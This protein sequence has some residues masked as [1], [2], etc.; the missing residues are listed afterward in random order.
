MT[1]PV[2]NDSAPAPPKEA[3]KLCFESNKQTAVLSSGAIVLIGTFLSTIFPETDGTLVLGLGSKLLLAGA[4]VFLG[5][6]L[7]IAAYVM[8]WNVDLMI[9]IE[10]GDLSDSYFQLRNKLKR[11]AKLSSRAFFLGIVCFA[12][13]VLTNLF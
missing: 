12:L 9:D 2:Q 4:F 1:S 11:A 7:A 10:E 5:A 3:T 13:A 6:A 8:D